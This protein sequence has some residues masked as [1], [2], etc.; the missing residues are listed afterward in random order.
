MLG[1][2]L[3][4]AG[5]AR[6]VEWGV[7]AAATVG[8]TD[9]ATLQP[10]GAQG[11]RGDGFVTGRLSGDLKWEVASGTHRL[12][13]SADVSSFFRGTQGTFLQQQLGWTSQLEPTAASS[14]SLSAGLLHGRLG[15]LQA[16][17]AVQAAAPDSLARPAGTL[18]YGALFLREGFAWQLG[19]QWKL[20]QGLAGSGFQ[21][22]E[23][24]SVRARSVAVENEFGLFRV[25]RVD[26]LGATL[27]TG[28][29]Y[30]LEVRREGMAVTPAF[31]LAFADANLAW[32][33]TWTPSWQSEAAAGAFVAKAEGR[34]L[35]GGPGG[36]LQIQYTDEAIATFVARGER[37]VF[38]NVFLGEALISEGVELQAARAFGRYASWGAA[39]ATAYQ[40]ARPV[41][42][43]SAYG[44]L[45]V[46]SVRG[47]VS[48]DDQGYLRVSLSYQFSDQRVS[49]ADAAAG[50]ASAVT[51][52]RH[53]ASFTL[54]FRLPEPSRAASAR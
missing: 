23:D 24:D 4:H 50:M 38:A 52:Q 26:D 11:A 18:S 1:C 27:R 46:W 41:S 12:S 53:L 33:R 28:Y 8:A 22:L 5:P 51:F 32:K 9:N 47:G 48:W 20:T 16:T 34:D 42:A 40:R 6:A 43:A 54:E 17:P 45:G 14:L 37:R 25:F 36:K 13:A 10:K 39:L 30:N 35:T 7:R 31:G 15:F 44:N 2:A 3:I 29:G 21:P 49:G 19:P